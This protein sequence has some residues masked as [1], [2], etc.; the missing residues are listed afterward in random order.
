MVFAL[1]CLASHEVR[2]TLTSH[3]PHNHG[4]VYVSCPGP[5]I[6]PLISL[7]QVSNME[8]QNTKSLIALIAWYASHS[9]AH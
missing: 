7:F 3:S 2:C 5:P 1:G 6:Q 8:E 9:S 4:S